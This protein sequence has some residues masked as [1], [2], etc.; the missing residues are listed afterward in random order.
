MELQVYTKQ[1]TPTGRSIEVSNEIFNAEPNEHAV[2]LAVQ[3]QMTNSRHG[4]AATK[5]RSMVS[6]G[7]KK[8]WKQ[9][10]RGGARAGTI[11]SPLWRGGG[12]MHGPQPHPYTYHLPK[13]VKLLARVSVLSAKTKDEQLKVVEDF[14]IENAKTKEMATI[15]KK[16]SLQATKTLFLLPEYD[17]QLHRASR[18]IKN[19]KIAKAS[20]VST[21][22]LLGC[23][24]VLIL[25]SAVKKLEGLMKS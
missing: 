1:G 6:G 5:T 2:Y 25:E 4:T 8:P 9:K 15:L 20:D 22:D 10:G 19:L 16:F 11:R 12:I 3:A 24:T 13:K 14:T 18:N 21:Y 7:G 17:S 23:K